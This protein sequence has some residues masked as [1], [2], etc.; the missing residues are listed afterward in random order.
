MSLARKKLLLVD[1]HNLG[2]A[3]LT[4]PF[5]R[6]AVKSF[7]VTVLCRPGVESIYR[8]ADLPLEVRSWTPPW[9]RSVT[10]LV[11]FYRDDIQ[12]LPDGIKGP[13]EVGVGIWPDPRVFF[14]MKQLGVETVVSYDQSPVNRYG[15]YRPPLPLWWGGGHFY[16]AVGG[17]LKGC[18]LLDKPL[19]KVRGQS[20]LDMWGDLARACGFEMDTGLPWL[21]PT[22]QANRKIQQALSEFFPQN[23]PFWVIHP[24]ARVRNKQWPLERFRRLI[25]AFFLP[26]RI[27]VV[28]MTSR[29][30]WTPEVGQLPV[31]VIQTGS[32]PE[33]VALCMQSD[34]VVCHDSVISHLAAACGK[35]V[36]SLFGTCY[37]SEFAP[38]RNEDLV[39][40]DGNRGEKPHL[41]R[42]TLSVEAVARVCFKALE[43]E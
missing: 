12:G 10:D 34:G 32:L 15:W 8:L 29:D 42:G 28:V 37:V 25:E 20:H 26:R 38:F 30:E 36:I 4:I 21:T 35:P 43:K 39:V 22:E 3:V 14:L 17:M 24:T 6:G 18:A 23:R 33:C 2:D 7:H 40:W 19:K 9:K 16:S 5:L 11:R 13:F 27:D 41:D 1:F 31:P